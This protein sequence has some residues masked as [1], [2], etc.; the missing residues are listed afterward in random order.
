MTIPFYLQFKRYDKDGFG[1][2]WQ[3]PCSFAD[4]EQELAHTPTF[5]HTWGGGGNTISVTK[6]P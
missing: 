6:N 3:Q 4:R 5:T 1:V 2:L